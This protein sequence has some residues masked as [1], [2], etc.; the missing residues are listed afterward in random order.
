MQVELHLF[1]GFSSRSSFLLDRSARGRVTSYRLPALQPRHPAF[2]H[3][4]SALKTV[5]THFR[6]YGLREYGEGDVS[7]P[8]PIE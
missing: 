2:R 1:H 4:V 7:L 5:K 8:I 6:I 3:H